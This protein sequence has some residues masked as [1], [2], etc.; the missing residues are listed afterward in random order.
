[1]N[2]IMR[3]G[4]ADRALI[5]TLTTLA[6]FDESPSVRIAAIEAMSAVATESELATV[7]NQS[8]AKE[9]SSLV[10]SVLLQATSHLDPRERARALDAF[11]SR[12]DLDPIVRADANRQRAT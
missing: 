7:V 5:R 12:G 1:M 10:Q 9:H 8:L 11:L 2:S 4:V 6:L 3:A